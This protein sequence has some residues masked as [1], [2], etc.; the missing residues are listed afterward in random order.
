KR[1]RPIPILYTP[2]PL[3]PQSDNLDMPHPLWGN[4]W[5]YRYPILPRDFAQE[6]KRVP[7][8]KRAPGPKW[9]VSPYP[10]R[11]LPP[12]PPDYVWYK[13]K[14]DQYIPDKHEL[15]RQRAKQRKAQRIRLGTSRPATRKRR[16]SGGSIRFM[17]YAWLCPSCKKQV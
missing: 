15:K 3:D 10:S 17:G 13:W 8:Y 12:P 4:I 9:D 6:I 7:I 16:G 11:K 14:G 5:E 2:R 1:G